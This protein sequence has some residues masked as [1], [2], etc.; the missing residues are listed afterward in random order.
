[1]VAM[2]DSFGTALAVG[3]LGG[4]EP[5]GFEA[6]DDN[7]YRFVANEPTGATDPSGLGDHTPMMVDVLS[8]DI[9]SFSQEDL[10]ALQRILNESHWSKPLNSLPPRGSLNPV[11]H[12]PHLGRHGNG[13]PSGSGLIFPNTATGEVLSYAYYHPMPPFFVR[14]PGSVY[15]DWDKSADVCQRWADSFLEVHKRTDRYRFEQVV[16]THRA[17]QYFP[18]GNRLRHVAIL[19]TPHDGD[20]FYI[21]NGWWGGARHTFQQD[22]IPWTWYIGF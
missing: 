11:L 8:W 5:L 2:R 6:G 20:S 15:V 10:N 17:Y 18:S 3:R 12:S 22:D 1:M 16:F 4:W 19:V 7:W 21:D 14:K 13:L 9:P